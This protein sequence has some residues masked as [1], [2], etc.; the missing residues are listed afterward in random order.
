LF[1]I[2]STAG[3]ADETAAGKRAARATD[4]IRVFP[5]DGVLISCRVPSVIITLRK[6]LAFTAKSPVSPPADFI[7]RALHAQHKSSTKAARFSAFRD[8]S[9]G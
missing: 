9:G 7:Q 5:Q 4:H 8:I 2:L 3:V 6:R 1:K